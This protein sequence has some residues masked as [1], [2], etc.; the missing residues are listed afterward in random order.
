[1]RLRQASRLFASPDKELTVEDLT[2]IE[3]ADLLA[4]RVFGKPSPQPSPT[5]AGEGAR[6]SP[7]PSPAKAGEGA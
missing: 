2:T 3:S 5:G 4:S 7:Q 1:A 6:P